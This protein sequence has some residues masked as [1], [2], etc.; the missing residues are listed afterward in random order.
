MK[1]LLESRNLSF[2]KDV[3]RTWRPVIDFLGNFLCFTAPDKLQRKSSKTT[4]SFFLFQA[5]LKVPVRIVWILRH[6]TSQRTKP[7]SV[8]NFTSVP[9][10]QT[11][12]N[13][14]WWA[15]TCSYCYVN[16]YPRVQSWSEFFWCFPAAM[17]SHCPSTVHNGWSDG[18][19]GCCPC[20]STWPW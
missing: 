3:I 11:S 14:N 19:W 17:V 16:Y 9:V 1:W 8:L 7:L 18:S 12:Y 20:P 10:V 2:R 5:Y 15:T 13:S 4:A 6:P